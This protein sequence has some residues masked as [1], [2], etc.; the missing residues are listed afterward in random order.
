MLNI[1]SYDMSMMRTLMS[2]H[3]NARF[4]PR[5]IMSGDGLRLYP[6][7]KVQSDGSHMGRESTTMCGTYIYT[8]LSSRCPLDHQP[9]DDALPEKVRLWN[10]QKIGY[11]TAWHVGTLQVR[12]PGF[13]VQPNK[14]RVVA[15]ECAF[16]II[17]EFINKPQSEVTV[18][19]A[20]TTPVEGVTLSHQQMIFTPE[21]HNAVQILTVEAESNTPT[22]ADIMVGF[23]TMSDDEVYNNLDDSW[24]LTFNHIPPPPRPDPKK[25]DQG[26]KMGQ[27]NKKNSTCQDQKQN[28]DQKKGQGN[29]GNNNNSNKQEEKK[30]LQGKSEDPRKSEQSAEDQLEKDSKNQK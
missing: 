30:K 16:Q 29:N 22:N 23:T 5:R 3:E 14:L 26:Q 13:K 28:Q 7:Y 25:K 11:E 24:Q 18:N 10:F 21:N 6:S 4:I 20:I 1:V 2:F 27:Q 17:V 9:E 19:I 15:P 12:A 8:M